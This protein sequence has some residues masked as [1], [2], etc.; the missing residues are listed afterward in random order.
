MPDEHEVRAPTVQE[1]ADWIEK[2]Y[3]RQYKQSCMDFWQKKYGSELV[4][5]IKN[6]LIARRKKRRKENGTSKT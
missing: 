1:G 6:E 2:Q 3:T 5:S 4:E